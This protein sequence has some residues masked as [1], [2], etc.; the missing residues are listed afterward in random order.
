MTPRPS[1]IGR[2]SHS[3]WFGNNTIRRSL[4]VALV[5]ICA[6]LTLFPEKQ[7][8]MVT[9]APTDPS[10]LGLS[11][12]LLQLGAGTSV[13]G[14]QAALDLTLKVGRSVRVR[15]IVSE[16][17]GLEQRLDLDEVHVMRWLESRVTVRALRG[18]I[19]QIEF[20]DK[21]GAFARK[22]VG[23]YAQAIRDTLGTIARQQ[24]RYKRSVLENLLASAS[25]R[26]E[27]AQNAYDLFRR[28]SEYGDPQTAVAKV[29]GRIPTLEQDILNKERVLSAMR[30]FATDEN[31][32]IRLLKADIAAV[33]AQLAEAKS[34]QSQDGSLA[35][36]IDQSTRT[37][38]L[39]RELDVSRELYYSYRRFLQGTVVEDLTSNANMRILEPPYIDPDR[40]L[41]IGFLALGVLIALLGLGV[42]FYRIRPPVGDT[43]MAT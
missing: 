15:R 25:S 14:S 18:G 16:E 4:V 36:V 3:R 17:L 42:E 11:D 39:R 40:Q 8:G 38:Q 1:I 7:R 26:L 6:V 41:N 20:S 24:T 32:Q 10:T 29:A 5:L 37:Q 21:D 9:L 43:A 27:R 2:L 33:R 19:I 35:Q 31:P 22:L 30:R 13:F 34:A 28:S 23:T 12:T